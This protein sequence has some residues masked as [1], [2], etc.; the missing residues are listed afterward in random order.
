[1]DLLHEQL[2]DARIADLESR[3]S[4]GGLREAVIR[5]LL[6]VGMARDS[7]DERGFEAIR[8]F[9]RAHSDVPLSVFKA[10]VREQFTMLLVDPETAL[11]AIPAMLPRDRAIRVE[12]F[13]LV[14]DVSSARGELSPEGRERL[15]RVAI[16][17]GL[18]EKSST[19]PDLVLVPAPA[20]GVGVKAS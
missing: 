13:E 5:A 18:D 12:A 14:E 4:A 17:F 6:Y 15:H 10:T 9:R 1:M 2:L 16:L 20:E 7:I 11:A 19:I 8:R 3:I